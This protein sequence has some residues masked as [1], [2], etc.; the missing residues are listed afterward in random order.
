MQGNVVMFTN[1]ELS[2]HCWLNLDLKEE[3]KSLQSKSNQIRTYKKLVILHI[4]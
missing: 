1:K 2:M 3:E 4:F